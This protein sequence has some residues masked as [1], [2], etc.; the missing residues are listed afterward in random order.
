MYLTEPWESAATN[1]R[2]R[3]SELQAE[4]ERLRQSNAALSTLF[5]ALRFREAHEAEAIL[6]QMRDG[7]DVDSII[8]SMRA[9]DLLLNL[10][11]CPEPTQDKET[12]S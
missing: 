6:Q 11:V 5:Q 9:G 7:V 3:H 10:Q 1:L 12:F 8:Q 2:R 4:V